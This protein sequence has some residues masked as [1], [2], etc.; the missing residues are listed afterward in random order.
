MTLSALRRFWTWQRRLLVRVHAECAACVLCLI[1]FAYFASRDRPA[2]T[3]VFYL[4]AFISSVDSLRLA[5]QLDRQR[6][7]SAG[8]DQA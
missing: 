5:R 4:C 8:Q 2:P 1:A 6:S 7:V 3:L